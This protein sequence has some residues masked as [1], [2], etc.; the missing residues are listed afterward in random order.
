MGLYALISYN[1]SPQKRPASYI[2][3]YEL[4][5]LTYNLTV[6]WITLLQRIGCSFN[7]VKKTQQKILEVPWKL[8][9]RFS[10]VIWTKKK[11]IPK[12][13]DVEW[14]VVDNGCFFGMLGITIS[15]LE[16]MWN[17][18]LP[19]EIIFWNLYHTCWTASP[20]HTH[21]SSWGISIVQIGFREDISPRDNS[22]HFTMEYHHIYYS[23][24]SA[25]HVLFWLHEALIYTGKISWKIVELS[26]IMCI[27]M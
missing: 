7:Q 18:F 15:V 14:D 8:N 24:L 1:L 21:F 9:K 5:A 10:I 22:W 16:A 6:Y 12:P 20:N 4:F 3:C 2:L 19:F 11:P 25:K 23:N 13:I 26:K 17:H 27:R